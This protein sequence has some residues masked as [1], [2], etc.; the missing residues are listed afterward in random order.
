MPVSI[1][2]FG[3][4]KFGQKVEEIVLSNRNIEARI[5]T[6]GAALKNLRVSDKAGK[7]VDVVLGYDSI[8]G[9]EENGG[10]VGAVIGR[11]ANRIA[12][13]RF[14]IDGVCHTLEANEGDN[15]LH[16]GPN[17]Y[18]RQIFTAEQDGESSVSLYLTD[19]D[20]SN[21]FPGTLQLKVTY[22]L[23]EDGLS[24]RY[25]AVSDKPTFC[26][27]T[28]HSYFNL[29]GDGKITDHVLR[30]DSDNYTPIDEECIPV[31][32]KTPVA[33]TPF[34]FT[35]WKSIGSEINADS[36]QLIN[37]N[38]YDHNYVLRKQEGVRLAADLKSEDSGIQ[39]S[40]YTNKPAIQLYT[41]NGLY[42]D[43][44]TKS[45]KPYGKHDA[46]CLETQY[47]PDSPNHPE[48]GNVA[49]RPDNQYDYTT[50]Y[51]FSAE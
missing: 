26:N 39:M 1:L 28:N 22:S 19:P 17:A 48:W 12:D 45:G 37:G 30:I 3:E 25:Q 8:K 16:G 33:N 34:D 6:Y 10:Y 20:G 46:V 7:H 49:L 38:G 50:Q 21:G 32:M 5:L 11:Y 47:V 36:I 24:L 31:E 35:K 18:D 13:A 29:N 9:Y 43:F 44:N 51:R 27:I 14:S 40:V 41:S 15:T 42:V 4:T 23:L 2:P